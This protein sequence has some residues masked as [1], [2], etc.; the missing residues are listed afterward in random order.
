MYKLNA[1]PFNNTFAQLGERFYTHVSPTR[2]SDPF[3]VHANPAA[4]ALIGINPSELKHPQFIDHFSGTTQLPNSTPLAMVYAGHQFGGYTP[5]L[6]DGRGLLLGE[7]EGPQGKWDLHLKGAGK[8][9]YSR[10]ADGRAVLRSSI[11]EYLASEA[12][13]GLG[14]PTTRALCIIGSEEPVYRE[15]VETGATLLRLAKTHIRFGSFE[16]FHYTKDFEGLKQLADY[17]IAQHLPEQIE[18]PN[19]YWE[20]LRMA[21]ES[22]ADMIAH[23]QAVGFA[24]GVMNT[25]NMSIIGDTFDYGPYGFLDDYNPKFICNH[26]DDSGR[27]A[28]EQQPGIGLWNLNALAHALSSLIEIEPL[29]EALGLYEQRLIDT[30]ARLMRQ[31]LGFKEARN[32]D[33]AITS[34]LLQLMAREGTDY[35]LCFRRLCEINQN[36]SECYLRD[37]FIDREAIDQWLESY[38]ARLQEE[39]SVDTE[40]QSRMRQAN[41]KFILRNYLAEIAIKKAEQERD[42]SEI[43]HL[44]TLVQ[45][46]YDEHPEYED[47][48]KLP[49][50]WGKHLEVSCSS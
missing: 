50:D 44:L 12:L 9:P 38:R 16:Y 45:S 3:L 10:F 26:S 21:V 22:T 27:Y 25:D 28:F 11:R 42:F 18:Q 8:T 5:R 30:Y 31:K 35:T 7:V 24:H 46:P 1:L 23:W 29:K 32:E 20:L 41:P 15:T 36:N 37:L 39:N 34:A 14:V 2:L 40:R 33:R 17:V 19:C 43:D 13:Y 48:A 49:P 4:A 47:Y 6:G